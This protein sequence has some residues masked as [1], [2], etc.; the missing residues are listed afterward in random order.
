MQSAE[1]GRQS[2]EA[3]QLPGHAADR[4]TRV[5]LAGIDCLPHQRGAVGGV[6]QHQPV[7]KCRAAARQ[8]GDEDRPLDPLIQ[9]ARGN[10]TSRARSRNTLQRKRSTSQRTA[11]RPTTLNDASSWSADKQLPQ[12]LVEWYR[13]EVGEAGSPAGCFDQRLGPNAA[14]EQTGTGSDHVR[15]FE[16]GA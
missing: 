3:A 15:R 10:A 13:A 11:N 8:A 4:G 9:D 7:Q 2:L 16:N 1:G 6:F 5:A 12:R 14:V